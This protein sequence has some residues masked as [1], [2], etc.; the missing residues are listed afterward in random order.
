MAGCCNNGNKASGTSTREYKIGGM[1]H[2]GA[3]DEVIDTLSH[4]EGVKQ[5]K[6]DKS[7]QNVFIEYYPEKVSEEHLISTLNSLGHSILS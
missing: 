3:E 5:V 1:K 4:I 6:V 7:T 2:T